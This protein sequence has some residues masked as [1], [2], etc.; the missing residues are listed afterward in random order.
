MSD[1][2]HLFLADILTKDF[3][4]ERK[5]RIG[6]DADASSKTKYRSS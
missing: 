2:T 5:K 1:L 3:L 4:A 6:G